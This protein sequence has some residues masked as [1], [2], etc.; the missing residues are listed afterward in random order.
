MHI[1][2]KA[3]IDLLRNYLPLSNGKI[4]TGNRYKPEDMS[5]CVNL[6]L[7][8]ENFIRRRY[9]EIEHKQYLQQ[10]YNA[11]LWIN[12]WCNAEE[13]RQELITAVDTRI[14]QALANH[15]TTCTNYN[16]DECICSITNESCEALTSQSSRANK[17]QC[18]DLTK[19]QSFFNYNHILKRTFNSTVNDLDELN[20]SE[21][22]LRTIFKLNMNYYNYYEIGGRTFTDFCFEEIL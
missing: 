12:I 15:Y 1:L 8:N 18:P 14:K 4:Y 20:I 9:V 21:P 19:Y 6:L 5:P 3:F 22:L 16:N 11:E 10:E 2:E 13:Q 17:N 7:A